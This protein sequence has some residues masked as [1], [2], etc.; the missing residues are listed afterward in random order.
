MRYLIRLSAA[1]LLRADGNHG[2]ARNGSGAP[3]PLVP[4][5]NGLAQ[6]FPWVKPRQLICDNRLQSATRSRSQA[7]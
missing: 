3:C 2:F 7:N 5:K 6:R 4:K 1:A